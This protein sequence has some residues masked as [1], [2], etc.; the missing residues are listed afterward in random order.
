MKKLFGITIALMIG[1][2]IV[3]CENTVEDTTINEVETKQEE[4]IEVEETEEIEEVVD[5]FDEEEFNYYM[6]TNLTDEEYEKYFSEIEW[7]EDGNLRVIEFDGQILM[8]TPHEKWNTRC[9][10]LLAT[11]D[12]TDGNFTGP[13]IKTRDIGY[14]Q[15]DGMINPGYNV[16]VTATIE[17]YDKDSGWLKITIETIE[18]R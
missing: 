3:G 4:I 12:Y 5:V 14:T 2:S 9:E 18:Q 16:K 11:G 8:V 10:L 13:Y 15:L 7:T 6:T 1:L 17:E